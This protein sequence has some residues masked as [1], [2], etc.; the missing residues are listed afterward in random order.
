MQVCNG[1]SSSIL[2]QTVEAAL[3]EEH[4]WQGSDSRLPE[5]QAQ[6]CSA[7]AMRPA[8]CSCLVEFT[9]GHGGR[10]LQSSSHVNREGC[11]C[12]AII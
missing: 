2:E 10:C 8:G 1:V 12:D 9:E 5:S 4:K 3:L 11:V 6:S 7:Y